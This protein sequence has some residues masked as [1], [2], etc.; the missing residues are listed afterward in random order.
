MSGLSN[1]PAWKA[2]NTHA[3][4]LAPQHLNSLFAANPQ[5]VPQLC[6]DAAGLFLDYS[7]QRI[8]VATRGLLVALARERGLDDAI[9][10]M[11]AG[12]VINRS[13]NRAAWHVA[14]RA[15]RSAG[16][17]DE[18]HAVLDAMARFVTKLRAGL[19]RGY[20]HKAIT[21][22][23]NIGIGGSDLG[24]RMVCR[25]LGE[26]GTLPRTHFVANADPTELDGVLAGL[27]AETTLFVVTSKS[28]STAETLANAAAARAWLLAAGAN[29]DAIAKHFVAV[30]SNREAVAEFGID[31]ANMFEFWD[32]VGGRFS[33]WSAVGLPIALALGMPVFEQLLA[34]A[35]AMDEHFRSAPLEQNLP[36]LLALV[37]IWNRNF[38]QLPSQVVA[39]YAQRLE[40]FPAWLQQLEMESNGKSVSA[41]GEPLDVATVPPLWGSIGSNAQH[42]YFQMLHQGTEITPV[43]FILATGGADPRRNRLIANCLAQAEALMVGKQTNAQGTTLAA[44]RA[45]AGNRPSNMLLLAELD[46][47]HLGALLAAYEHKVYVQG[48]IW[49]INSFD[50]WGVELGK[51]L[52]Q[53]LLAELSGGQS[54]AHDAST[55]ALLRKVRSRE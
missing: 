9:G 2:L 26:P 34:G 24:P 21:D 53:R 37:G 8:T 41:T 52:A 17:P 33:L 30:S 40:F 20:T 7:K 1:S 38:L 14:L 6:V 29:Q 49:G 42:A 39:P 5:R 15:P 44:Q 12:E 54:T 55:Q 45:F 18:V 3:Q 19:W 11:F 27:Q 36:V 28:F 10:A 31:A 22:V 23:V 50:Q 32:W 35:H 47:R 4:K 48:V 43:D 51:V 13:E 16:Y 46:A 25:A